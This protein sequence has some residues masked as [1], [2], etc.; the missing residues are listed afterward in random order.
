MPPRNPTY[1][2]QQDKHGVFHFRARIPKPL[3]EHFGGRAEIKRSL[4]TDSRREAVKRARAFRVE[5]DKRMAELEKGSHAAFTVILEG[6]RTVTLPDGSK[7]AVKGRIERDLPT[8]DAD[9]YPPKKQLAEQ[10]REEGKAAM[11]EAGLLATQEREEELHRAQLEAVRAA[12]PPAP[13]M[14]EPAP[15]G[16]LLSKVVGDY[17]CYYEKSKE[18]RD[19]AEMLKKH[20]QILLMLLEL[21]GDKPVCKLKKADI[22]SALKNIQRLPPRWS[23]IKNKTGKS[24]L[25]IIGDNERG[26]GLAPKT[27]EDSYK[28]SVREFLKYAGAVH[29]DEGF[30]HLT[31]DYIDYEG[32]REE[33]ERKQR[34]MTREELKLLFEGLEMKRLAVNTKDSHKYWLPVI[35]LYTG[36]RV[37]EICQLNPQVDIK[38]EYGIWMFHI[39]EETEAAPGVRKSVKTKTSRKV[40]IH[41]K[42]VELG[43]LNYLDEVKREGHKRIFPKFPSQRGKAGAKAADWFRGHLKK[44]GLRD[45]TEGA[46]LVGLHALRHTF[47][48]FAMNLGVSVSDRQKIVG[49]AIQDPE[50]ASKVHEGYQGEVWEE[51]QKKTAEG[52]RDAI[53]KVDYGLKHVPWVGKL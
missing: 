1:L 23:H 38:Q 3:R 29:T 32:D 35:G 30:P 33:D 15:S 28:A 51:L 34:E 2:T 24:L 10:L 7:K 12:Y 5:L 37:N 44:T 26:K 22:S 19:N 53:E 40:P 43:F 48:N 17:I 47:I 9:T 31:T 13:P 11:E 36:A 21:I 18:T 16:P 39:T 52:L 41:S 42:I 4:Q 49:H 50:Q 25:E 8:L 45:D 20:K 14:P 27:F 46:K 6:E